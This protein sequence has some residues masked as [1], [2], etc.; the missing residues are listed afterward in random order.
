MAALYCEP[1]LRDFGLADHGWRGFGGILTDPRSGC[2]I[3]QYNLAAFWKRPIAPVIAGFAEHIFQ[4]SETEA[5]IPFYR[6]SFPFCFFF[7]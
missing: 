4:K 2:K 1:K 7:F 6:F 3:P 5:S